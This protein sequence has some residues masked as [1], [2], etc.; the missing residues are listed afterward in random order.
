MSFDLLEQL[1]TNM[2]AKGYLIGKDIDAILSKLVEEGSMGEAEKEA[3][4][5]V[6]D[7]Y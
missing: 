7:G 2:Y 6:T 3:F 5:L 1:P 4:M